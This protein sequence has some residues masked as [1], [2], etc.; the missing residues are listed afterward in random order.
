M[1]YQFTQLYMVILLQHSKY[2]VSVQS[3]EA[4]N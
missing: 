2:A 1:H 4:V 3:F